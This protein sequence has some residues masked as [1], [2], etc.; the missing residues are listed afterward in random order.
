MKLRIGE[1]LALVWLFSLV[2]A[3]AIVHPPVSLSVARA[4]LLATVDVAAVA[5]LTAAAGALGT[6]LIPDLAVDSPLMRMALRVL[7]GLA[8]A[9]FLVLLLGMLGLIP[10]RWLGWLLLAGGLALMWRPFRRWLDDLTGGL[11]LLAAP[12]A[13]AFTRWIKRIV[14]VM[15]GLSVIVALVPPTEWD[16]LTYHLAGPQTYLRAGRIISVPDNHFF[17]FPQLVE[18]LYLWLMILARPHASALLHAVFGGVALILVI[19][20]GQRAGGRSTGWLAAG[21]LL[22]VQTVLN[23]FNWSYN[24][25][26]LMAYTLAAFALLT[27]WADEPAGRDR[28][29]VYAGI[30]TGC[31]MGVKYTAAGYTLG[32]AAL[33]LWLARRSGLR[34]IVRAEA[35]IIIA[36]LVTFLP[37]VIKNTLLEGNPLAPFLWGT[38]G[39]DELDQW[40]YL[41]PGTGIPVWQLLIVPVQATIFGTEANTYQASTGALIIGL[42]PL[43]A[44]GWRRREPAARTALTR[45]VIFAVPGTLAWLAGVAVTFFLM[46]TRLLFPLFPVYA[47]V[48]AIGLAGLREMLS[49]RVFAR[50]GQAAVLIALIGGLLTTAAGFARANPLPVIMGFQTDEDYL[51][52][53]LGTHYDA[54][55]QVNDLPADARIL[56]LWEPRTFYCERDCVP[57]SMIDNWWHDR[58][59]YGAPEAIARHWRS[60]GYTHVL[61]YDAGGRFLIE[62]EPYDPMTEAD[63]EALESLRGIALEPVWVEPDA[64]SLYALGEGR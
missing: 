63:W 29:L 31:M 44:L 56:F 3:Y 32:M 34:R 61:I 37:W 52:D 22:S 41:R 64:Y 20:L 58:E 2:V 47:L 55:Q 42:L 18:M 16:A 49:Q 10:P 46:Q 28:L 36:A 38:A 12:E 51:S 8:A 4:L 21:V 25:L 11:S 40:Y 24:D 19:E 23:A 1:S 15:L 33:A 54:I 6:V 9:S 45:L 27:S 30:C 14:L 26:A 17:S 59:R 60:E 13:D 7:I 39:F 48:G 35:L 43:A 62:E 53:T 5:G 50:F 57:D